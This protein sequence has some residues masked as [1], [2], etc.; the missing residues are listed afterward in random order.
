M[1]VTP[2]YPPTPQQQ[3]LLECLESAKRE[4]D[5]ALRLYQEART[6]AETWHSR[7]TVEAAA[8]V[9][10]TEIAAWRTGLRLDDIAAA[11]TRHFQAEDAARY[12][13]AIGG[14]A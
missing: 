8:R 2:C 13:L 5:E 11:L 6:G 14:V 3:Q 1:N 9:A 12:A 4:M 7:A 10:E